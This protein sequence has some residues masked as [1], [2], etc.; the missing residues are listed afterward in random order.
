MHCLATVGHP[1]ANGPNLSGG[2]GKQ[3]VLL[4]ASCTPVARDESRQSFNG[5]A[6]IGKE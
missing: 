6:K 2:H 3:H 5:I 4:Y 1:A